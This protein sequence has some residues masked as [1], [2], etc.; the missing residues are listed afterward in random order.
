[1]IAQRLARWRVPLGFLFGALVLWLA[2]P[3]WTSLA[4]GAAVASLG[5][6]IRIWAAGHVEKSREV[7]NS[8][9]YQ[10]VRHPLYVGSCIIGVGIAVA[11]NSVIAAAIVGVYLVVTIGAAIRAEEAHLRGKFGGAYDAYAT[12]QS[13]PAHRTFSIE[14]A[15]RNREHHTIAGLLAAVAMLAV[16]VWWVR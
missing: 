2:T 8:G 14:R 4:L 10:Y 13:L 1:M 5:E 11:A 15:L 12:G 3:T 7:T 16:K 9:P 6:A